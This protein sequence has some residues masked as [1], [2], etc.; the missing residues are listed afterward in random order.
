MAEVTNPRKAIHT[1]LQALDWE[2]IW[3]CCEL[4]TKAAR[5]EVRKVFFGHLLNNTE[6]DGANGLDWAH[7]H[8]FGDMTGDE[9]ESAIA[10]IW[11]Q[12]WDQKHERSAA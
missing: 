5:N 6:I 8:F 9:R 4:S 1:A 2:S 11:D 12:V 3:M 10:E 7:R